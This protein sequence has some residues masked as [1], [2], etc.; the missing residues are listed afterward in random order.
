MD[1][2]ELGRLAGI[3]ASKEKAEKNLEEYYK[4]PRYCMRCGNIIEKTKNRKYNEINKMLF[5]GRD[6]FLKY[7]K[8]TIPE[9]KKEKRKREK[10]IEIINNKNFYYGVMCSL[11]SKT[12]REV[13]EENTFW[14]ARGRLGSNAREI[15][16]VNFGLEFCKNCKYDKHV[17]VCH[18]IPIS[19]FNDDAYI[20][21]INSP[22]N[23]IALCPNCHWEFDH[24]ILDIKNI[25]YDI[26]NFEI[27]KDYIRENRK[28]R[29]L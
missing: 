29:I 11:F 14:S 6:C 9:T 8:E 3:K 20:W 5:C 27:K 13:F 16:L 21:E 18:I 15:L 19:E 23:L 1:G 28:Y 17:E 24:G 12:K 26:Q 22:N 25:I 2:M 4:N 7:R 10:S